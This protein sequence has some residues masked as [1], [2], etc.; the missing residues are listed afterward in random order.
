[1][2]EFIGDV[3]VLTTHPPCRPRLVA[4]PLAVLK[5]CKLTY[6]LKRVATKGTQA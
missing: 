2:S 1:V 3:S 5:R 6:M 4:T